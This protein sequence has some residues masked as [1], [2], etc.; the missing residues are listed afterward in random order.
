[1]IT[2][3]KLRKIRIFSEFVLIDRSLLLYKD[4]KG[5]MHTLEWI[6]SKSNNK[7]INEDDRLNSL[8]IHTMNPSVFISLRHSVSIW[9]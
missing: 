5:Q 7:D 1:V 4:P 6:G 9:E 2:V 8:D 3:N